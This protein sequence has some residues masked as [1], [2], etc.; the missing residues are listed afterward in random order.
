MKFIPKHH[1][2]QLRS[3]GFRYWMWERIWDWAFG[4]RYRFRDG[5][6]AYVRNGEIISIVY[7]D[8]VRW[9]KE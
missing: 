3:A 6:I 8:L 2:L 7:R 4:E 1:R 5:S 9:R